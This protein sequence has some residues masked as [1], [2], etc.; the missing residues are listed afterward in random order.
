L[1]FRFAAVLLL[2]CGLAHA[3]PRITQG[4]FGGTGLLQTPTA[5]MAP[6]GE[7]SVKDNPTQP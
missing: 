5:R 6:A 1:N 2:P 7:L 4:D 3:E